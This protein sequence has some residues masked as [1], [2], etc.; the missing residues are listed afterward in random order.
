MP[1]SFTCNYC[2]NIALLNLAFGNFLLLLFVPL[3]SRGCNKG[4]VFPPNQREARLNTS[5]SPIYTGPF[6]KLQSTAG[7]ST[8]RRLLNL[9]MVA[10]V[11][12]GV[13]AQ[14]EF[15]AVLRMRTFSDSTKR[16]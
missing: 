12:T 1:G 10:S 8:M 15:C 14:S 2:E 16:L 11:I 13:H 4:C 7:G 5:D 3:L 9:V 6:M